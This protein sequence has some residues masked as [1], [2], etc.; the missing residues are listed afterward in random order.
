[1]AAVRKTFDARLSELET[2]IRKMEEGQL[3]LEE[4]LKLYEQGMKLHQ[5]LSQELDTAEKRM[6]ELTGSGLAEMENAP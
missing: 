2:I 3:S 4:M 6:L 1:M 5:S